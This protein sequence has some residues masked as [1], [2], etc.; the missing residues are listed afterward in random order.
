MSILLQRYTKKEGER[1]K[2]EGGERDFTV[3]LLSYKYFFIEMDCTGDHWYSFLRDRQ[4][5]KFL[6]TQMGREILQHRYKISL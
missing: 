3:P 1:E 2:R 6:D 5:N 4:I